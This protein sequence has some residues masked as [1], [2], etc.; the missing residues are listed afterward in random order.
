MPRKPTQPFGS[1]VFSKDGKVRHRRFVLPDQKELQETEAVRC[2]V[3]LLRHAYPERAI[4]RCRQLAENDHD[5]EAS[6]HGER[7]VMQLA[8]LVDRP[9]VSTARRSGSDGILYR[10]N[11]S[12]EYIDQAAKDLALWNVVS[13]KLDKRYAKPARGACGS[14]CSRLSRT[15]SS[16]S[17]TQSCISLRP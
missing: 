6:C 3:D 7:I 16:S 17:R 10:R 4:E 5:F 14:S 1:I 8:E 11:G 12:V 13:R 15:V 2:F 9:F